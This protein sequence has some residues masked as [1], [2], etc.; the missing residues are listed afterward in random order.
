MSII[1]EIQNKIP[2]REYH[3][4]IS[5]KRVPNMFEL[6]HLNLNPDYQRDHVWTIEQ[7]QKFIGSFLEFDMVPAFWFNFVGQES[8]I[9]DGKQR[10][11]A[12]LDWVSGKIIADCPCGAA[13]HYND[14]DT[15]DLRMLNTIMISCNFVRL[16]RKEVMEFYIRLNSGGT[17]HTQEEI[18]KVKDLINTL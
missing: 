18:Q 6:Y 4:D 10:I 17:V 8:E 5:I 2:Q 3:V 11:Q 14:L 13:I 1:Q 9:I 15:L 12:I 7:K 16:N